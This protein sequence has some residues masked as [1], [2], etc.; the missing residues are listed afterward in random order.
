MLGFKSR[1]LARVPAEQ[2]VSET[3][4]TTTN[5]GSAATRTQKTLVVLKHGGSATLK[6]VKGVASIAYEA[7]PTLFLGR[8]LYNSGR[9]IGL[10]QAGRYD[11]AKPASARAGASLVIGIA[12][13][14]YQVADK[15][16]HLTERAV[17]ATVHGV[18]TSVVWVRGLFAK[19]T[20]EAK[21]VVVQG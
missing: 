5:N 9:S 15:K 17:K 1:A 16:W 21:T 6:V 10:A 8:S 3:M 13:V 11:L 20:P 12:L 14:T 19:K 7:A 18:K 2:G 4:N